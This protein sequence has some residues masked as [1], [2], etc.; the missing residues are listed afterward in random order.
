MASVS[1]RQGLPAYVKGESCI[2]KEN[3]LPELTD[4]S[5]T[6]NPTPKNSLLFTCKMQKIGSSYFQDHT[7]S[8]CPFLITLS[9]LSKYFSSAD[10]VIHHLST[11]FPFHSVYECD[12]ELVLL[13]LKYL[14]WVHDEVQSLIKKEAESPPSPKPLRL[15][16]LAPVWGKVGWRGRL[17]FR[18]SATQQWKNTKR[19]Q[20]PNE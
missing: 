11:Y 12:S 1:S 16:E 10:L 8:P 19:G 14:S 2:E 7:V 6:L 15:D 17:T 4:S 9:C 5:C 18:L 13:A 3:D 20:M